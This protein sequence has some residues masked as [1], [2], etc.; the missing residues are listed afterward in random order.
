[1]ELMDINKMDFSLC[2]LIT[3]T[4]TTTR[5]DREFKRC[6]VTNITDDNANF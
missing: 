1:M 3:L 5:N 2:E 4:L 6:I